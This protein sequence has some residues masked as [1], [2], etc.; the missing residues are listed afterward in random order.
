M[1]YS[2]H[3]L[4]VMW[5]GLFISFVAQVGD[6]A[7]FL[8]AS[9]AIV[10]A[11]I[12]TLW[13]VETMPR[14]NSRNRAGHIPAL[15]G[16]GLGLVLISV[17]A[18]AVTMMMGNVPERYQ[19][20][21]VAIVANIF[22]AWAVVPQLKGRWIAASALAALNFWLCWWLDIGDN[23][24]FLGSTIGFFF[25]MLLTQWTVDVYKELDQAKGTEAA[26]SANNERLRIAQQLHDSLG[27]SLA[28]MNL[29]VQVIDKLLTKRDEANPAL[30]A[31]VH[32]LKNLLNETSTH[33]RE[34]VHD[35]R[36]I[37]L[38]G[39]FRNAQHLLETSGILVREK[40]QLGDVGE[41]TESAQQAAGWFLREVSTNIL[42]HSHART[43]VIS[44]ASGL[45][46]IINDG[47]TGPTGNLGGLDTLQQRARKDGGRITAQREGNHFI[48][49]LEFGE[50]A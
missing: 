16:G 23:W 11:G 29:K 2:A 40:G 14:V 15:V 41:L 43:V 20:V 9:A 42:R 46:K 17:T 38:Y 32:Q 31:E 13:V 35:Y 28:A 44:W 24:I 26:L 50:H 7:G 6:G 27:Q 3:S 4:T 10:L 12:L 47:V 33:M 25:M 19:S 48:T 39:E 1:R 34:V 36:R 22:L 49:S 21:F 8:G 30:M 45:I 37:D 5:T 18:M